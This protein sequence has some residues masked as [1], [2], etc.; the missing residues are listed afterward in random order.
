MT[1]RSTALV[2]CLAAATTW[3]TLLAWTPFSERPAGFL[4]P[5]L[6]AVV[7]VA[8]TGIALRSLRVPAAAVLLAQLV[9]VGLWLQLTYASSE[10]I[11]GVVPTPSSVRALAEALVGGVVASTSYAA[12]VPAG[13]VTFYPLLIF[14]GA[15][16]AVLV[17][18]LAAGLRRAPLAGLPL[19][20]VYTAPVSILDGGV[21]WLKFA[22]AALCFCFLVAAGEEQR[23]A[24]WGRPLTPTGGTVL[25]RWSAPG[26]RPVWSSAR[27]IGVTATALSLAAPA[28]LP[29][30]DA[31]LFGGGGGNR[32]RGGDGV[33]ISNPMVDL[34]RDLDQGRDVPLVVVRTQDPDPSYLRLTVLD[35]FNGEEWRPSDRDIPVEQR[36]QGNLTPPPGL[37]ASVPRREVT[38]SYATT[39]AFDSRWLPTPYPAASVRAPGD[40]RFDR[41]TLDV[42]SAEE[43]QTAAS[44]TYRVTSLALRP[45]AG[46]LATATPAPLALA[47]E[48]TRVPR[49]LPGSVRALARQVTDQQATKFEKAVALQQFFRVDGGFEYSLDR[50]SGNGTD[51]LV[52][53]LGDGPDSRVGY[54]EQFAA[55]MA[56]MGRTLGIPSRVA[57]GFLRPDKEDDQTYVYSSHDLHAWPEMYFGGI[58]WVRFEPTPAAQTGSSVPSYTTQ[59]IPEADAPTTS[60]A[61]SAA[62]SANRIERSAE[63]DAAAE[64][65]GDSGTGG[66]L[67]SVAWVLGS[68]LAAALLAAPRGLRAMVRRRRW[69]VAATPAGWAEAAWAEI[70]DTA[71]DL[72]VTVDERATIRGVAR[73]LESA[74]GDPADPDDATGRAVRRG[75]AANPDAASA[76]QRLAGLVERGRYARELPAGATTREDVLADTETCVAALRAG[77]GR[78]R[79]TR[80]D[81]LPAS[82]LRLLSRTEATTRRRDGA[83]SAAVDRTVRSPG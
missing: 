23:L 12:P 25:D 66:G 55:A 77:A 30:F 2:S 4:L 81:W 36:A 78:R 38:S 32:G 1:A 51:A 58:G 67:S 70:G 9:V 35:A 10:A 37:L 26:S 34:R 42:I 18:L 57:V 7:L 53:F 16:T 73:R 59:Q 80:A 31:S 3:V 45:T 50:A 27:T 29:A 6:L 46:D 43:E 44:M 13:V 8:G 33:S 71:R 69:S 54:C 74:F 63:Q 11:A 76:L 65:G 72:A 64:A 21:S 79:R 49:G 61:P 39:G 52:Q 47:T 5:L 20:A 17:D 22:A 48:N 83:A 28:L 60:A 82:V 68:L 24:S 75:T 15:G 56:V 41:S 62:A 14:A 40:W 19:L